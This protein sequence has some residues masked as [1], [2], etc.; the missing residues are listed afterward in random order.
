MDLPRRISGPHPG[1]ILMLIANRKVSPLTTGNAR[2]WPWATAPYGYGRALAVLADL[3]KLTV[4]ELA[5]SINRK[6]NRAVIPERTISK[7][8]S[9]ELRPGQKDVDSL[10]PYGILDPILHLYLDDHLSPDEIIERG[11]DAATVQ[12]VISMVDRAEYKRRQARATLRVISGLNRRR[13]P[14]PAVKNSAG[15]SQVESTPA[16]I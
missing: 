5:R 14:W 4:Y 3:P 6:H 15:A 10:P 11:F 9:A 16:K 13:T 1:D 12:R 8:P 7:P 2:S